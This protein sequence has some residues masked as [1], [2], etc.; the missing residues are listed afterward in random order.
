MAPDGTLSQSVAVPGRPA[1]PF[2]PSAKSRTHCALGDGAWVLGTR[3]GASSVIIIT[4]PA[5]VIR[6]SS[7][8]GQ[9]STRD[10]CQ[11][12]L[13]GRRPPTGFSTYRPTTYPVYAMLCRCSALQPAPRSLP[14]PASVWNCQ[15][16]CHVSLP[17][18]TDPL[19]AAGPAS[20]FFSSWMH[21]RL[22]Y[23]SLT[24]YLTPASH[25]QTVPSDPPDDPYVHRS[26][27]TS[28]GPVLPQLAL[29]NPCLR[30]LLR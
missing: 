28:L 13:S 15:L 25:C 9:L 2:P 23:F 8:G 19:P 5:L 6:R 24:T 16:G 29:A 11:L 27:S 10:S 7:V 3:L 26:M 14:P 22:V 30:F 21:Y 12:A 20:S 1:L 4:R 18:L 17:P